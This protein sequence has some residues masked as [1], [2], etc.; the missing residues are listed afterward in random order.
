MI[1]TRELKVHLWNKTYK[2]MYTE[3]L[4]VNFK[5]STIHVYSGE[6][7]IIER[8][9]DGSLR[10]INPEIATFSYNDTILLHYTGC[11]DFFNVEIYEADILESGGGERNVVVT[12]DG[13]YKWGIHALISPVIQNQWLKKIGNIYEN[14]KLF[15]P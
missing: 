13:I 5:D 2:R 8:L 15:K 3:V 4:S 12:M 14:P 9:P 11:K 10:S 7:G 1:P 6:V